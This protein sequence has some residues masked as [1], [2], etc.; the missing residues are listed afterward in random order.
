M[1]LVNSRNPRFAATPASSGSKSR[2]R[3]G[4]TFSRSYGVNLPNSLAS[5]LSRALGYS[6]GPPESVYGTVTKVAPRAAFLGSMGSPSFWP[7]RPP[8]RLS[9]LMALRLSLSGPR[10]PSYRLEPAIPSAGWA[11]PSPSLLGSTLPRWCRNI[12]LLPIAYA[13]RPRLRGRLTLGR[14]IL[15]LETLDLRRGG[16][17]PPLSL[18]MPA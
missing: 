18:L 13:F 5:V 6:P 7:L 15:A 9:E 11:Y 8:H 14:M 1:F 2:H 10:E 17:S 12:N 3:Q 16:F 4:H